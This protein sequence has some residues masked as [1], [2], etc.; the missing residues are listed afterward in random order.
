MLHTGAAQWMDCILQNPPYRLGME[1][2][3][4]YSEGQLQRLLH[5][6]AVAHAAET[7]VAEMLAVIGQQAI[8]T[9]AEARPGTSDDLFGRI[10]RL[11]VFGDAYWAT[12]GKSRQTH[13]LDWPALPKTPGEA[14]VMHHPTPSNMNAMMAIAAPRSGQVGAESRFLPLRIDNFLFRNPHIVHL[15]FSSPFEIDQWRP[16]AISDLDS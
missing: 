11:R 2:C 8:V 3:I 9:L 15:R 12:D 13:L 6:G 7:P 5:L 16:P 14:R 4:E 1:Q 10:R